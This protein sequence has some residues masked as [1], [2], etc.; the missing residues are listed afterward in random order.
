VIG[1]IEQISTSPVFRLDARSDQ[2]EP[3]GFFEFFVRETLNRSYPALNTLALA[4]RLGFSVRATGSIHDLFA[5]GNLQLSAGEIRSKSNSWEVGPIRLGLP[6][7]IYYPTARSG[8]SS[9]KIQTG[10][11]SIDSARFGKESVPPIKTAVSL[12][13]NTLQFRQPIRVSVYSGTIEINNLVWT[14]LMQDAQALSF[15]LD[16]KNIE[17][18]KLTEALGW[19]RF[20]GTLTGSIP[21]IELVNN[22]LRS[23]G[24][25]QADVFGGRVQ[26]TQMEIENPFSSLPS[27]RLDALFQEIQLERA[28]ETFEFGR[29]SGILEGAISDLLITAGQPS[30]LQADIYTVERRGTS[31]WINVEAL[32]KLT[33]LSSGNGGSNVYGGLLTFFDNFRY[34]KMGFKATLK[35]DRLTLR[36]VATKDGKEFLVVGSLLPPTV[37]IISHTQEIGF[38]ELLRRLERIK[39]SEEPEIK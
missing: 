10:T 39:Q 26:I 38:S 33:V 3:G 5:E 9:L 37:N 2:V 34:S 21:R 22:A 12:W 36:G 23:Q 29:I 30:E 25:I 7:R 20:G 1:T 8:S 13:N 17:L 35:N 18:S 11:L 16:V 28:S 14:S 4:G 6:F 24:Q 27:I 19:Y 15:S 32:N 31:Q